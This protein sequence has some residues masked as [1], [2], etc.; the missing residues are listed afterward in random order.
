MKW[1]I[2]P[3]IIG[4]SISPVIDQSSCLYCSRIVLTVTVIFVQKFS[5]F[6]FSKNFLFRLRDL[7][8]EFDAIGGLK[9]L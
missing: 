9:L 2:L 5:W 8:I 7:I 6:N 3:L 4:G 1:R